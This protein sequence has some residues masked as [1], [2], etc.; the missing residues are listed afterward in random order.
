MPNWT[1]NTLYASG[2]EA[3]IRAFIEAVKWED[4]VFDFNRLIPMPEILKHTGS[5]HNI[6]DGEK[7]TSWYV[8]NPDDVCPG[9]DGVRLFTPE[10]EAELTRIGFR[11]WYDWCIAHW[12]T[13]WNA[14]RGEVIDDGPGF[15]SLRFETAWSPPLPVFEAMFERFPQITFECDWQD[16]CEVVIHSMERPAQEPDDQPGEQP[17]DEV[18]S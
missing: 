16:E 12:G 9:E 6:I 7:V 8:I 18:L 3:D 17:D 14:V 11:S 4:R 2:E 10:E 5:G 15:I 13:K 1:I